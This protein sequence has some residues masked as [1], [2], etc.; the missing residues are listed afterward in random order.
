MGLNLKITTINLHNF[1][2]DSEGPSL[3]RREKPREKIVQLAGVITEIN[4]DIVLCQEVG[5]ENSLNIFCKDFL[6]DN[7]QSSVMKGNSERGIQVGFLIKKG[8]PYRYE[9]FTHKNRKINFL[10]S[11]EKEENQLVQSRG[12]V[13]VN[14]SHC[15]S[16]DIAE[17]RVYKG[18]KLALII[19]QVHLKSKKDRDGFDPEGIGKRSAELNTLVKLYRT[20]RDR[21]QVPIIVGG[22]FNG[23][24]SETGGDRELSPILDTDLK[25]IL[26]LT[27]AEKKGTHIHFGPNR[28]K[29]ELQFDYLFSSK[30]LHTT[31]NPNESGI[32]SYTN[33]YGDIL[34]PTRPYELYNMPSD[35]FPLT[36]SFKL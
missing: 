7:Y 13:P 30:E 6:K 34:C 24:I 9:H 33:N 15:F 8:L 31:I 20:M 36:L 28:Q 21:F 22:D 25:D 27:G 11:Y 29:T 35:H 23:T 32:H 10:Y 5:G 3:D 16:R 4:P 2:L 19:F 17:L 12:G 18:D 26:E 14:D 1:F